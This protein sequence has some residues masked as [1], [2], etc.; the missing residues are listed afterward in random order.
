MSRERLSTLSGAAFDR[1]YI[2]AMVDG[3]RSAN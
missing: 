3:H 2:D 1:A